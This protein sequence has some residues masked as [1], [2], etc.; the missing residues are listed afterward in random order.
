VANHLE[1]S[2]VGFGTLISTSNQLDEANVT[3]ETT[4]PLVFNIQLNR[5]AFK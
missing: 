1:N 3:F 4:K 2:V 5:N